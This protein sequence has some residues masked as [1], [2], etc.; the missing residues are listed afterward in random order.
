MIFTNPLPDYVNDFI[1]KTKSFPIICIDFPIKSQKDIEKFPYISEIR[2]QNELKDLNI[3]C[4]PIY[5][6]VGCTF[7]NVKKIKNISLIQ[8]NRTES[9]M[10]VVFFAKTPIK[11]LEDLLEI[12]CP[13][14]AKSGGPLKSFISLFGSI[15]NNLKKE[16]NELGRSKMEE[17][18]QELLKNIYNNTGFEQIRM[19]TS[20]IQ[21]CSSGDWGILK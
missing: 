8:Y 19:G 17:K 2:N 7:S 18:Y 12:K 21:R 16:Y 3:L 9:Y 15:V 1:V 10:C 11:K 4:R 20:L 5:D 13:I 14:K 6:H